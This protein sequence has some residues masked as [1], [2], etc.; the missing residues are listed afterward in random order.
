MAFNEKSNADLPC[1]ESEAT[2][3][4]VSMLRAMRAAK[5]TLMKIL[6]LNY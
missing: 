4:L 5:R 3:L 1:R 6:A 2:F